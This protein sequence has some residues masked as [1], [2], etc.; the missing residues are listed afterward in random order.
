MKLLIYSH[1]FAPSVGGV[2]TIV[3]SLADGIAAL[4]LPDGAPWFEITLI[5][6]TPAAAARPAHPPET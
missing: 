4:R 6:N 3:M 5:T 1:Y 2:E